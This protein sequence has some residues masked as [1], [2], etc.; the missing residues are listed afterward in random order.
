LAL[1]LAEAAT[2]LGGINTTQFCT[3]NLDSKYLLVK[4]NVCFNWRPI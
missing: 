4:T 3:L 2:V 1:T